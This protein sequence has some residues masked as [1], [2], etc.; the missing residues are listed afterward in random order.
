[1]D[2]LA[3]GVLTLT[4]LLLTPGCVQKQHP[5]AQDSRR[6]IQMTNSMTVH[7][8][9]HEWTREGLPT[10]KEGSPRDGY[11]FLRWTTGD[12]GYAVLS[13]GYGM[14]IRCDGFSPQTRY[15]IPHFEL[16]GADRGPMVQ[17]ADMVKL[18]RAISMI[19]AGE[20]L[21]LFDTCCASQHSG[22]D[23]NVLEEIKDFCQWR[24]IKYID[25]SEGIVC[26]CL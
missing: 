9:V 23:P 20:T 17:T 13:E 25:S 26:T 7:R 4:L 8:V 18:K 19:P 21:R 14:M 6:D 16:F 24:E 15:P 12:G 3:V 1:M 5:V 22:M 2:I 10:S 11:I